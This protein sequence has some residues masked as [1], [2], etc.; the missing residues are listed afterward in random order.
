MGIGEKVRSVLRQMAGGSE[1]K[2]EGPRKTVPLP[3]ILTPYNVSG[4]P[5]LAVSPK[6]TAA[7]LRRFAETPVARRAINVVKDKIASM[8]WQIRVRRGYRE[9]D[10]P[11]AQARMNALRAAL[12]EPNDSDSF[13]TLW[14]QVIEDVLVGG[15]GSVEM[16][17]TGDE[18]RPFELY[19]VDGAAIHVDARWQAGVDTPRYGFYTGMPGAEAVTPLRDDELMY[20]RLNPRTHT[21]FG[22]GRLE[23]AFD[24]VNQFLSANRYAGR[25]ASNSVVQYA[26]WLDEAT[27]EQHDRLIRWWQDEIEG[28]GRVPVLS[29]EKKPEVLKFAGGTDADLRIQWQEFLV[30]MIANAFELPP[31]MLGLTSEVNRSTAGE[32]A[33]EAFQSAVVPVAKLLA[34]HITRDLFAK[35]LG[36]REFEFSF[37]DL[38]ERDESKE[39]AMQIQL[40]QAGVL[41]VAEVRAMRGL[42]PVEEV[43]SEAD[44]R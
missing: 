27:P 8:D 23:V 2:V 6:P 44:D 3:S 5:G 15:F 40:L 31:M 22:L 35:K 36:W 19:A 12:E 38:D 13:R 17:A 33:D 14:E 29:C 28:T 4:R 42:P 11:D 24:T 37:N 25:L 7:N 20:I 16:K 21:P 30:T 41:S 39:V 9:A 26:L 43:G 34:E 18:N 10:V 1:A 32:L